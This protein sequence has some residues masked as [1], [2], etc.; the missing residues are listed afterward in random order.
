[1]AAVRLRPEFPVLDALRAVGALAVLTTHVGFWSGAYA[2][3]GIWGAL[4]SR[5]DVGVAIF[6]VLSGFLLSRPHLAAAELRRPAPTPGRYYWKRLLRIYPVYFVTVVLALALIPQNSGKGVAEWVSTLLMADVY[7][8][9]RLPY[10][11]TQMWSLAVEVSFYL[12]LPL[13]M[14]V[15]L[16]RRRTVRSGRVLGVL[17]AMVAITCWWQLSAAGALSPH[18]DGSPL[19]WLPAYLSWFAAGIG[20]AW[21]QVRLESGEAGRLTRGVAAVA[22]MPGT[23]FVM[24]AG[25][26]LVAATPVAGPTLLFVA[27]P[28][29][30]LAKNLLYALVGALVV[31]TGVFARGGGYTRVMSHRLPRHLGD[32]SYGVF[33][34][35]LPL[36][37]L[38][39]AVTGFRLF[40]GHEVSLWLLT[41]GC[42]LVAAEVLH[43][44]VERPAMRLRDLGRP[45]RSSGDQA[46][47]A[48]E[49]TTTTR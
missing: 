11:L 40:A 32:L 36:M 9:T 19:Q 25:L 31:A 43:R 2:S 30:S 15:I 6:F 17:V 8:T 3:H 5:L 44:L 47:T 21:V 34:V 45:R 49:T 42:S 27:S 28:G 4:V 16:G 33:C 35:H 41:L 22:A 38:I 26:M 39:M 13:L 14:L 29:A 10:G 12:V 23:C 7:T 20:L 37:S 48:A 24:V 1:M 18:T 46:T